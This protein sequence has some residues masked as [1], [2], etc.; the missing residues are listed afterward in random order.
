MPIDHLDALPALI[1]IDLQRGTLSN[2]MVRPRDELLANVTD[3]LT[4]FRTRGL[5]VVLA[6]VD[7]TPAGR[8][9]YGGSAG[10]YPAEFTELVPE[11]EQ[12]PADLTVTRRAWSAFEGT[13]LDATLSA[14]G[15]TQVVIAGVAT[16]FGVESTARHAYDSG[17]HVV[18][19]VDAITDFRAESHENSVTRIFPVLGQTGSTAE[20]VAQLPS[21]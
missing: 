12:Q 4:A 2:P 20:I 21:R 11:L 18:F 15:V 19:A 7:G 8:N 5:P 14:L 6:N 16:S 1:V 3:L 10:E 13:D 17:Y 9:D